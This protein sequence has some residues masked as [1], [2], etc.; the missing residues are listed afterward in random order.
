ME[1]GDQPW[2]LLLFI[3]FLP[4]CIVVRLE[5]L[6]TSFLTFNY[7]A[8]LKTRFSITTG[9]SVH[10]GFGFIQYERVEEARHAIQ[11]EAGSLYH[12]LKIDVK[13]AKEGRQGNPPLKRPYNMSR[14]RNDYRG[15]PWV[16]LR[17]S[18]FEL[19]SDQVACAQTKGPFRQG[20]HFWNF[21]KWSEGLSVRSSI[22][23]RKKNE[24][25]GDM[26][27]WSFVGNQWI[28]LYQ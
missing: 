25:E 15:P 13:M 10:K 14:D 4:G 1:L 20:L 18:S 12:G 19:F 9:C 11:E 8:F 21:Q 27:T 28:G 6:S 16:R 17:L 3:L 24:N 26:C 7:L 5:L 23:N 22:I 2:S